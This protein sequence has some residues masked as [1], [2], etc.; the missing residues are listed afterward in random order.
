MR[1]FGSAA[2][3]MRRV[4]TED[5]PCWA[6]PPRSYAASVFGRAEQCS[7]AF[8]GTE[9]E[10]VDR[11][12]RE[13]K[14]NPVLLLTS[15]YLY[16]LLFISAYSYLLLLTPTYSYMQTAHEVSSEAHDSLRSGNG[17]D[18]SFAGVGWLSFHQVGR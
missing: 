16:L 2:V 10:F 6:V 8:G 18:I 11:C 3:R 17:L 12:R 13:L 15:A 1:L 7:R 9:A 5:A 14:L 4:R